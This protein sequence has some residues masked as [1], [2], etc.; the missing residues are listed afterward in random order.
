MNFNILVTKWSRSSSSNHKWYLSGLILSLAL[1]LFSIGSFLATSKA[2]AANKPINPSPLRQGIAETTQ[3]FA[4]NRLIVKFKDGFQPRN[5]SQGFVTT[6]KASLDEILQNHKVETVTPL[7]A[8]KPGG[9]YPST[10]LSGIYLLHLSPVSGVLATAAALASD[11]QVEWVEPDYLAYAAEM[12]ARSASYSSTARKLTTLIPDDPL[13]PSQWSLSMINAADAWEMTTGASSLA[14]AIVDS[15]LDFNHPD[16][17]GKVWTNPGEIPA[18]GVDDDNNGYVDDVHGWDFISGDNDPADS[19][20][21]GTQVAG[22]A[23]AATNNGLGMAGVCWGCKIMP[24]RVMQA[25]VANYSDIAQGV[26]YAAQKG[27]KVINLSLGG[28][29]SSDTL[30]AAVNVATNE[31]GA[32]VIAGTGNDNLDTP[33]YPAALD[34][35]LAV[36]GTDETDAKAALSNYGEWVDLAA[37]AVAITT[38]F[39][40][41][42]WGPVDGT[43]FAAPIVSGLAGLVRSLHPE[44]SAT[45][46]GQQLIHTT[47]DID[48]L[49]PAYAGQLGSGRINAQ[50]A[51]TTNPAPLLTVSDLSV[52]GQPSGAIPTGRSVELV[53]SLHNDWG[54][55]GSVSGLLSTTDGA[56]T[57]SKASANWSAIDSGQTVANST[58]PFQISV[59]AGTYG[60]SIP[61]N[62]KITADGQVTN[63]AFSATT[64]SATVVVG[65]TIISDTTWT[66]DRIY[67][68][69][70]I[71][72][73]PGVT[74][75][76]QAGV[77]VKFNQAKMMVVKGTLIADGTPEQPIRFTSAA[78]SPAPGDWGDFYNLAEPSGILFTDSSA[79]A[80]FD[81]EGNYLSGSIL[82]NAILEYS[83]GGLQLGSAAP[84]IDHNL[85]QHNYDSAIVCGSCSNQ[86]LISH[87]RIQNNPAR[88]SLTYALKLYS[89]QATVQQNLISDNA[90]AIRAMGDQR[91]IS[92]TITL[93]QGSDCFNVIS[94]LCL[95]GTFATIVHGNNFLANLSTYDVAMGTGPG[96][97]ADVD[98]KW[99]YWDTTDQEAIQEHIYDFN[100]DI[101]AGT[102]FFSPFLTQPD[103][104]APAFLQALT[105]T[106]SSPVGI[107]TVTFNLTFSRPMDTS[108]SPEVVFYPVDQ[109]TL[110]YPV[111]DNVQWL[112][113]QH[114]RATYD[115]TSLIQR[116]EYRIEVSRARSIDQME[117]PADQRFTFTVDYAGAI[118]DNT[119][120]PAPF[121]TACA[122]S[123]A[124]MLSANWSA[125]DP[126]SVID[127]YN[128]AIGSASGVADVVNWTATTA[129]AFQL[130]GLVLTPG[131]TYY[132]SVKARNEGGLW[133]AV[134]TLGLKAGS[135][136]CATTTRFSFIPL[137]IR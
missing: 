120:P 27:A 23:A 86:L 92:N 78:G 108:V 136:Q 129:V 65:G 73:N 38:T 111:V 22:I 2:V 56:V 11:P 50:K 77:L 102:F 105:L 112:D 24:V 85:F 106:P 55:A 127:L 39:Q 118:G 117:I 126:D 21:H 59:A 98:G 25:G 33:F 109:E 20:G 36:A 62:L 97:G 72:V 93:N 107:Q 74:L 82:R 124:G 103:P 43:S 134:S 44:W 91:I 79:P 5:S 8:S 48:S 54:D 51:I 67:E 95:E 12:P 46:A 17:S 64:E 81:S 32:L 1:I 121:L 58:D 69:N 29:S 35:V 28:Y 63:L 34:G 49:N 104:D 131:Q 68:A 100:Q 30:Q 26:L 60:H 137:L 119:P 71:I 53:I 47:D 87:N 37:P 110:K 41:G 3:A 14:I 70:N 10:G 115:I 101:S 18:N 125:N 90:G 123:A 13:F 19:D 6:G 128:Y 83:A 96:A 61:F 133:S 116:G 80:V 130:S 132:I 9:E 89:G 135:D 84:F 52:D 15:G 7:F 113:P 94:A 66:N 45:L 88:Q 40:G 122:G 76:I 114:W 31:Y 57:V 16:L 99:N 75:T 42:D 4:S